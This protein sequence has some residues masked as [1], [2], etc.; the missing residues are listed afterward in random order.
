LKYIEVY[1][2]I[3]EKI[4]NGVYTPW[5]TLHGEEFLCDLY[6]ISRTTVRKA[7]AKLKQDGYIH[8]RQGSGIFVNPPE[9]YEEQHLTTIS[10]RI[11]RG[12]NL[13]NT[14]LEF[15]VMIADKELSEL[16]N[17]PIGSGVFYYKR[18]RKINGI[19][20]VIEETYMPQYL[21]KDFN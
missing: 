5:S 16:F 18:I 17:I 3:K 2:D 11:D 13:E 20:K 7:L 8:T 4:H 21:F 10:E 15:K 6:G 9:F 14:V 19:P 12:E 1:E